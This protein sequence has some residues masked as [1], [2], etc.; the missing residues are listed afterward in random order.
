VEKRITGGPVERRTRRC[1]QVCRSCTREDPSQVCLTEAEC[2]WMIG[3]LD[4]EDI[5]RNSDIF[6][7]SPWHLDAYRHLSTHTASGERMRNLRLVFL[8][9]IF[10]SLVELGSAQSDRVE[11]FG[12]YSLER[13]APGCGANYRCGTGTSG[14]ATNMS[15]WTASLTGF[16]YRS[17]GL[18]AQFTGNYN[19]TAALSYSSVYRHSYQFGPAYA[20][21]WQRTSVFAHA[22]FG[23]VTQNSSADQTL[24][25]TKFILSVGG[26]LDLKASSR[27]SIRP[28]QLDYEWQHVPVVDTGGPTPIAPNGDNGLRYSAGIV[29]KF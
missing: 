2:C 4:G 25:Y 27:I 23:G 15:G 20:V 14:P 17:L 26:G 24:S 29:I 8:P 10:F 11:L 12:G 16:V 21:R 18:S 13:I 19:G 7:A 22:L 9:V 3:K 5:E 28:V 1:C 6:L